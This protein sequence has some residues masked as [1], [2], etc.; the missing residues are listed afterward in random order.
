MSL[1]AQRARDAKTIT[2]PDTVRSASNFV[3]EDS[4]LRS[5]IL[6]EGLEKFGEYIK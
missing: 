6:N 2:F 4:V 3:F 5:V 1:M